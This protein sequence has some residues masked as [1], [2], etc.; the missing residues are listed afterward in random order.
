M[1]YLIREISDNII[2]I[3]RPNKVV[4]VLGARRVGKQYS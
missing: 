4:I 1:K 2:K 3:L